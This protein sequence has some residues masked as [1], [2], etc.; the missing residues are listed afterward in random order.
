MYIAAE[1]R[2]FLPYILKT[3]MINEKRV[4][5]DKWALVIFII[6]VLVWIPVIVIATITCTDKKMCFTPLDHIFSTTTDINSA[7]SIIAMIGYIILGAFITRL[8]FV[9]TYYCPSVMTRLTFLVLWLLPIVFLVAFIKMPNLVYFFMFVSAVAS[10]FLVHYLLPTEWFHITDA[11]LKESCKAIMFYPT[12]SIVSALCYVLGICCAYVTFATYINIEGIEGMGFLT[13]LMHIINSLVGFWV[14]LFIV[15][16][17]QMVS[18]G[19]FATWYWHQ[20]KSDIPKYT[21]FRCI[22]II[23][24][25]HLG[26]VAYSTS[27]F[28]AMSILYLLGMRLLNH[29][30]NKAGKI[31][32]VL[33]HMVDAVVGRFM[34][35]GAVLNCITNGQDFA[36]SASRTL[37]NFESNIKKTLLATKIIEYVLILAYVL[38]SGLMGLAIYP[39]A[40]NFTYPLP[41]AVIIYIGTNMF[42]F[43]LL[44][45]LHASFNAILIS[46]YEDRTI[47][48]GTTLRP[49]VMHDDLRM[50]F[51]RR[52]SPRWYACCATRKSYYENS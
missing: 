22:K 36:E 12:V 31:W 42:L 11:V 38:V 40:L 46:C 51:I 8:V 41:L 20:H 17:G 44:A 27:M 28:G 24:R 32:L 19:A 48:D 14:V 25:Y 23:S 34:A 5:T 6:A 1:D 47:N 15:V 21:V 18:S 26:T 4:A 45:T 43:S 33:Y 13:F 35:A 16:F 52:G 10:I 2:S 39:Y 49:Y 29:E 3:N 30:G 37:D 7:S 9:L 50:A